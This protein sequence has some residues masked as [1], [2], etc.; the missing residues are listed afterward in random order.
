MRI[1]CQKC[2]AAYA[3]DDKLVTP[4][5]IRAQC[6]RCRHLQLVKQG[7]GA[8]AT[9]EP[10]VPAPPPLPVAPPPP[11]PPM[12]PLPQAAAPAGGSDAFF[13]FTSLPT[14][15]AK[16]PSA[17]AQPPA[18]APF[19]AGGDMLDFSDLGEP[20]PEPATSPRA[21]APLPSALKKPATRAPPPSAPAPQSSAPFD[22]SGDFSFS[23]A[24]PPPVHQLGSTPGYKLKAPPPD[25]PLPPPP[26][27]G[28]RAQAPVGPQVKCKSCGKV[29]TDPFDQALG[30]CDDCRN[31]QSNP[32]LS[33]ADSQG[34]PSG[35]ALGRMS[36]PAA[37]RPPAPAGDFGDA[38]GSPELETVAERPAQKPRAP[39]PVRNKTSAYRDDEEPREGAGRV[40]AMAGV[41]LLVF[42]AGGAYLFVK[43]PWVKKPPPMAQKLPISSA[44]PIDA[45]VDRW[46]ASFPELS[47]SA[48]EH[49]AAGE[50]KL[51]LDTTTAYA[52][53]EVE[54]QKALVLDKN[55]D[56]AIAGWA[57]A[58]A[59]GRGDKVDG[60]TQKMAEQML[61][62]AEQRGGD[63]RV[64]V[65]HA[66][67]LLVRSAN[68]NDIQVLAERGIASPSAK[69]KA[70]AYL[71]LGQAYLGKNPKTARDNLDEALKADPKLKRAY[72]SQVRL[73]VGQGD[74]KSAVLTLEKR[75]EDDPDQLEA[76]DALARLYLEVS[77][78]A[79]AKKTYQKVAAAAPRS[80]AA[81]VQ[82]AVF[83]Y[84]HDGDLAGAAAGLEALLQQRDALDKALL[85]EA[86]AHRAAVARLQG[87]SAA[88][89]SQADAALQLKPDHLN[90]HL[91][92]LFAS[93]AV[94]NV[95]DA[96][97]QLA[98]LKL[99]DP[100]LE[101]TL[102]GRVLLAEGKFGDAFEKLRKAAELDPRRTD[103][104][105]LAAAAAVK[106][107]NEPKGWEY[108]LARGGKADPLQSGP[109]PPMSP[110][111]ISRSDIVGP[112]RGT[113]ARLGKEKDDPNPLIAEG[114][115]AWHA[116][117]LAGADDAFAR[118][119]AI[120]PDNVQGYAYRAL[121]SLKR[122]DAAAASKWATKAAG[123]DRSSGLAHCVLGWTLLNA[124]KVEAARAELQKAIEL[125]PN[126]FLAKVKLAE[127][128][129]KVK[130]VPQ[131][132]AALNA[133]LLA[134]PQYNEAKRVLYGIS[135]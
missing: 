132:K 56:R 62:A 115:L 7:D 98:A 99:G 4:K 3:I 124:N 24:P 35:S 2:S 22:F 27:S 123:A 110:L 81:K 126:L 57:M 93:L 91:Q 23:E 32:G 61:V 114:V 127:G 58:L 85:V 14:Q 52:E 1:V 102:E 42:G 118:V 125:A 107:K 10:A 79:L 116:G 48:A 83:A 100:A 59:F 96:R 72:L 41:L 69:D 13:D 5:G 117:D 92:K 131:A 94:N 47:G 103:A 30:I 109:R 106:A 120:D 77:E 86:L 95:A 38:A 135:L 71:A 87:D 39:A 122:R 74:Y 17:A 45:M 76:A 90:A 51:A 20:A 67:L 70:L 11:M 64:Y 15:A 121:I 18:P 16:S 28:P 31:A 80:A 21:L 9:T 40:V 12:P 25:A 129:V 68:L 66:H 26:Q 101:A 82:L 50:E 133:V 36:P 8:P 134:D 29:L 84:Q 49:L 78:P 97:A 34:K 19:D 119:V 37:A 108:V 55:N 63:A 105:L 113:F 65:A 33:T 54:F 111:F 104:L 60:D 46:K 75:L 43:K 130:K 6:P 89:I 88:A 112:A 44:R 73:M 53:A 128:D